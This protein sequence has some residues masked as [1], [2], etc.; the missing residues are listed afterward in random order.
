MA[1]DHQSELSIL[2]VKGEPSAKGQLFQH[3]SIKLIRR[4]E[5]L[6]YI[7]SFLQ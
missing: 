3:K 4:R 7:S 6:I 1:D 5:I 2:N